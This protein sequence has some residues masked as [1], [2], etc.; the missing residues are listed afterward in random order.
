MELN[1]LTVV[2]ELTRTLCG[3]ADMA[4][5]TAAWCM[6]HKQS[7]EIDVRRLPSLGMKVGQR[8]DAGALDLWLGE[9]LGSVSEW[10]DCCA[11]IVT[12]SEFDRARLFRRERDAKLYLCAHASLRLLLS[13]V[14]AC[15][16]EDLVFGT[17]AYGKPTLEAVG[18]RSAPPDLAFNLSHSGGRVLIGIASVPVGVD[19]EEIK[20]FPDRAAVAALVFSQATQDMLRLREA[21]HPIALFYRFWVLGEAYIKATGLGIS[22]GL[23][24]FTLTQTGAPRLTE[25]TPGFGPPERW[26]FGL[27]S[28]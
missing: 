27:L 13:D 24:T 17:G 21:S 25:A 16:P 14:L 3:S 10:L 2:Q 6:D 20:E 19:I 4:A 12:S 23:D 15:N 22:Q 9:P 11:A 5:Y 18:G 1:K 7:A 26:R 28:H 8:P